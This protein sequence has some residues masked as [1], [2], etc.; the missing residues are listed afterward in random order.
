MGLCRRELRIYCSLSGF[1]K[2]RK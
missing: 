2:K 1:H